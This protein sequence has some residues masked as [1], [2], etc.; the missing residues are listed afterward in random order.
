MADSS[1]GLPEPTAKTRK[2]QA[3]ER[4]FLDA[5]RRVFARD[6]YLNAKLSDIAL[7]AG[8]SSGSF[9]NYFDS[10]Q[11]VLTALAED[12]NAE[13]LELA[14]APYR[15]GVPAQEALFEAVGA[16]WSTYKRRLPELAG[17]FQASMTDEA[18]AERWRA[19]RAQGITSI[20]EGIRVAQAEGY[21]PGLDPLLAASALASMIEHFCYVWQAQ[22]GDAVD[23]EIDDE[24]AVRT[25]W[26]LWCHAVFWR[27]EDDT[28]AGQLGLGRTGDAPRAEG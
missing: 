1:W 2:G 26:T 28:G 24:K 27:Q 6:G 4:L 25:L 13:L 22:G 17:V 10:K 20:A 23:V 15:R 7:E 18:F 16:F 21:A 3:T 11:A 5:A 12:F 9:Y 8:K 19:I 14:A